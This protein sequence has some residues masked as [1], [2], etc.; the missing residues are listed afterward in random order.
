MVKFEAYVTREIGEFIWDGFTDPAG[1][2]VNMFDIINGAALVGV[3]LTNE[4]KD[5]ILSHVNDFSEWSSDD[6]EVRDAIAF[7]TDCVDNEKMFAWLAFIVGDTTA[8]ELVK[9]WKDE[10]QEILDRF[11]RENDC[12]T[13]KIKE[14]KSV[15]SEEL[16][17]TSDP[18]E[19]DAIKAAADLF[20]GLEDNDFAINYVASDPIDFVVLPYGATT[21]AEQKLCQD[22]AIN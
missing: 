6:E 7:A 19:Q 8:D 2:G 18:D 21:R 22:L 1:V 3:N 10:A 11:D 9:N 5:G 4:Q 14:W 16:K 12:H 17:E 13:M 20:D 15:F